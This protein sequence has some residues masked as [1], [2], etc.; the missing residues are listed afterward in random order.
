MIGGCPG[1]WGEWINMD[2]PSS[3]A[4]DLETIT[5]HMRQKQGCK[6]PMGIDMRVAS[7]DEPYYTAGNPVR[8]GWRFGLSCLNGF[9]PAGSKCADFKVRYCCPGVAPPEATTCPGLKLPAR[10]SMTPARARRP[11]KIGA[12]VR[13]RCRGGYI[14]EG[15][16]STSC[17]TGG[18]WSTEVPTCTKIEKQSCILGRVPVNGE[19]RPKFRS[20]FN[21]GDKVTFSCRRNYKL[22]GNNELICSPG[23]TWNLPVP[24]CEKEEAKPQG[25]KGLTYCRG[26]GDPHYTTFDKKKFDFQGD[27]SYIFTKYSGSEHENFQVEVIN[28]HR[29]RKLDVS[30]LGRAII[31]VFGQ[32][33]NFNPGR[34]IRVNVSFDGRHSLAVAVPPEYFG[35]K[36]EGLCGNFDGDE[37]NDIVVDGVENPNAHGNR[38]ITDT[39]TDCIRED[40]KDSECSKTGASARFRARCAVIT[41]VGGV[42]SACHAVIT[43]QTFFEDCIFDVCV[44]GGA[45]VALE[46]AVAAYAEAC[47]DAGVRIGKWREVTK[48]PLPCPA[49]A[50]YELC[51]T[52]C[53]ATCSDRSPKCASGC[54]EGCVCNNGFVLS[55]NQC[56]RRSKCGCTF[57]GKYY[58]NGQTILT[59]GCTRRCTCRAQ[60]MVC[61]DVKCKAR[62]TCGKNEKGREACQATETA[63]CRIMGGSQ[64]NL[65]DKVGIQRFNGKCSYRLAESCGLAEDDESWFSVYIKNEERRNRKNKA[66]VNS[67]TVKLGQNI[68]ITLMKGGMAMVNNRRVR[69]VQND[70]FSIRRRG[71]GAIVLN[72]MHSLRVRLNNNGV[73]V[74]VP[75]TYMGQMCGLCGNYNKDPTDDMQMSDGSMAEDFNEFGLSH[76]VESCGEP[77]PDPVT[78]TD[79]MRAKWSTKTTCGAI[80]DRDGVFKAC[81]SED[82]VNY[83]EACI[84]DACSTNGDQSSF[85]SAFEQYAADCRAGGVRLCDWKKQFGYDRVQCPEH[86]TYNPCAT[87]CQDTCLNPTA[88]LTCDSAETVEDC[89]CDFGYIRDGDQCVRSQQCGCTV[90][91]SYVSMGGMV[92]GNDDNAVCE[93]RGQNN[94]FCSCN[95]GYRLKDDVCTAI[96]LNTCRQNLGRSCSRRARCSVDEAGQYSCQC[97][98]GFI[99]NGFRCRNACRQRYG[100]WC[101]KNAV[102]V[103]GGDGAYMCRCKNNFFGNGLYCASGRARSRCHRRF[104]RTCNEN[105]SCQRDS[106]RGFVCRCNRGYFGNGFNCQGGTPKDR[107]HELYG[108]VC[109]ANARCNNVDGEYKCQCVGEYF[110]DGF[111]CEKDDDEDEKEEEFDP[112][113]CRKRYGRRCSRRGRCVREGGEYMCKCNDNYVGNGLRCRN[114]CRARYGRRCNANARCVRR[115]D[116]QFECRCNDGYWGSGLYCGS[117]ESRTRCHRRFGRRCSDNAECQNG[118]DGQPKC[119]CKYGF[120]GN[121]FYC[122]SGEPKDQCHRRWGRMCGPNS[123]CNNVNGEYQCQCNDNYFGDGFD[124][125]PDDE[126]DETPT[127]ECEKR[128][129]R[130]CDVN[131]ACTDLGASKWVCRCNAGYS[132]TGLEC[133]KDQ[134]MMSVH[135]ERCTE[136]YTDHALI[137]LT[138]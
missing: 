53:P 17:L 54:V 68:E 6:E 130:K 46:N 105:A 132:G 27:C 44:Y 82:S 73:L 123:R 4:G 26:I 101:N 34:E 11:M 62:Q 15:F 42:F 104:G 110:G 60:G 3:G 19:R 32:K 96:D 31:T 87:V 127:D 90:G 61:M 76:E 41:E 120:F 58:L 21:L 122:S 29:G 83:M 77:I 95:S 109:G 30:W 102:C 35:G 40:L 94:I 18:K 107:C 13:F 48:T 63:R 12:T 116:G 56:V 51:A 75:S 103:R 81:I 47:N 50:R 79:D 84:Y 43:A 1:T 52:K 100:R 97:K 71:R 135:W 86:S 49:N 67:V 8:V 23:G 64:Y 59:N 36:L 99:G 92:Q 37:N 24:T 66:Y 128:H 138:A 89:E 133:K 78:C 93:C 70:M 85:I 117:G 74:R 91:G 10:G 38:H 98:A 108:Q 16:T 69:A 136:I 5:R 57:E 113:G 20:N 129:N 25:P 33:I 2:K 39:K 125:D 45:D 131:A 55:G 28:I 72:T 124:C 22:S 126:E 137:M 114:P 112:E 65:F 80:M 7:N 134:D 111:E 14:M 119:A 115:D 121:G 118:D 106:R 88:S 9:Q